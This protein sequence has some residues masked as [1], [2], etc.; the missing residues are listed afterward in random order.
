[1]TDD[2]REEDNGERL[3]NE[4][5]AEHLRT[6]MDAPL[7]T[8]EDYERLGKLTDDTEKLP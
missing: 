3:M 7:E 2:D 8:D 1:M 5:E 6:I 4:A